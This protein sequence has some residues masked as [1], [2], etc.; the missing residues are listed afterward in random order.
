MRHTSSRTRQDGMGNRFTSPA[1]MAG[2]TPIL[3]SPVFKLPFQDKWLHRI[4]NVKARPLVLNVTPD[5]AS[6]S[7]GAG[8]AIVV[9]VEN[10]H[11]NSGRLFV[12][13]GPG[14]ANR[15]CVVMRGTRRQPTASS[16]HCSPRDF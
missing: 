14:G 3:E 15:R 6:R 1:K 5:R 13:P 2:N 11:A 16:I 7:V 12:R 8:G 4:S 10:V 9:A